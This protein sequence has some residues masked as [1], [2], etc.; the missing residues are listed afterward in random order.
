MYKI[1]DLTNERG[2]MYHVRDIKDA[3]DI[4]ID[5]TGNALY[6]CETLNIV[7]NMR[8]DDQFVRP[9]FYSITCVR[10]AGQ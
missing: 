5:I 10:E 8:F 7:A 6:G 2:I 3:A 9:N 1:K 4:V